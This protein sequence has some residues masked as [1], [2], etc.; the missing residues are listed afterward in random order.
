MAKIS[1]KKL[2]EIAQNESTTPEQLSKIWITSR[3]IKVRKAIASNPN[4]DALTLRAAAHLYL[5]EV[6]DNPAFEML[7][8][9]GDSEWVQKIGEIHENPERWASGVGYYSRATGQL[10]PFARA[11]LLSP[12]LSPFA[13]ITIMEFLPVSSLTRAFKY[14]K[15]RENSRKMVFDY[16]GDFT[17]EALFKAYNGGLYNEE[18]LFQCLRSMAKIG[19]LSCRKS[20]YTRTMKSLLKE[21]EDKPEE[22]GPTISIVLLASRASCIDWVKY[23]FNESHLPVVATTI[24]AAKK[25]FKKSH[26]T[27][28]SS[29]SKTNIRVVSSIVTSLLWE[30]LDFEERKKN[31]G[32]FYKKIC[33]LGL[34]NHEWGDS[35]KTW[36]AVILTNELCESLQNESIQVKSFYVRNKCLGNWF[37]VQKSSA[38]FAIVEE[39]NQWLYERGG[40]E[41]V[42]Y[43]QI[44]LKKIISI[45]PDVVIGF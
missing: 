42:L 13:M 25:V 5:E 38:K 23:S 33:Q 16:A 45:S 11:A 19:S 30:P 17:M 35:K 6:L 4:A 12:K 28:P 44:D 7:K 2:L 10:E 40:I 36:G 20:T 22:V 9:F 32:S 8:L 26:G 37:H 39:V 34:E 29:T 21:Y 14:P 15:T 3:S 1:N 24:L 27:P 31:L 41:N 18:E 43:K